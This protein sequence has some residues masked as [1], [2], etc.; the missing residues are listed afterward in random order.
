MEKILLVEDDEI[1]ALV[2]STVLSEAG[3]EV[4]CAA[5]YEK[6]VEIGTTMRP[7]LLISDWRLGDGHT[8]N[9]VARELTRHIPNLGVIFIS[10]V[11]AVEISIECRDLRVLAILAKP[12][13]F[14]EVVCL[15]QKFFPREQ[16]RSN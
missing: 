12:C 13:D 10:G 15:V 1:S 3:Y 8:G 2:I 9:E 5:Q 4:V 14:E 6:A 7:E 11:D 16:T